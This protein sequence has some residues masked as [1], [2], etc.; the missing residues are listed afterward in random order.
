MKKVIMLEL[1]MEREI[2]LKS[3]DV[4]KYFA[5]FNYYNPMSDSQMKLASKKL[6]DYYE[7]CH[8][9]INKFSPEMRESIKNRRDRISDLII[10]HDENLLNYINDNGEVEN[11]LK[12]EIREDEY[13]IKEMTELLFERE[14]VRGV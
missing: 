4:M 2:R 6:D 9:F 5:K 10:T 3:L 7:T 13:N 14:I 1:F 12:F 8:V 11:K